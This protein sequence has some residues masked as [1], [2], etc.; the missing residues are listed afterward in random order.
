M[1]RMERKGFSAAVSFFLGLIS[2]TLAA[3]W[4][5][6]RGPNHDGTS[7][8]TDWDPM[9][10]SDSTKP[11]WTASV[12][13]GFSAV[14]VAEGK[15]VTMGNIN[16]NTDVIWCFDAQTGTLLWKHTYDEPLTPNLYEGGPNA[17][18]TIHQGKVYTISKTGK[19]FCLDLN[20]GAVIWQ[21]NA[22]LKKPEWGYAGSPL[23]AGDRIFLN[24]G[25]T[26]VALHKETGA[27]LWQ[28]EKEPCGYATA[29]IFPRQDRFE[30][31]L[32]SKDHLYSVAPEDGRVLWAYPWKTDWDVNASDPVVWAD[33]ILITSGYNR[34]ASVLKV[35][36]EGPKKIWENK[37]LRSQL[38]GPILLD[39]C[40]YGID[41]N[42]LVCLDWKTGQV[43]WTEKS[44]GKGTL[45]AAAGNL[46]VLSENG[47]LMIAPASPKEFS[48]IASAP[49]LKGRCW[50][51]PVLSNGLI[52]AR[53]AKGD[54][55]CIDVR[56][57]PAA[58][59][60]DSPPILAA[61]EMA[62]PSAGSDWACW[63][64]PNRDNRSPET[65]LLKEWPA[66]GPQLL[67][68]ADDLGDGYSS[69]CVAER[70]IFV[71]GL[72][73]KRGVLTCLDWDGNRLW[74]ADYG[75]E[76]TGS[77]PGVRGAP[78]A[79]DGLLYVLSGQGRLVCFSPETGREKWAAELY[80]EFQGPLPRWGVS[81]APVAAEGKVFVT[82]GGP[83]TTMAAVDAQKGHVVWTTE[84]L[85]DTA[86][87][88]TPAIFQWAG[89]TILAGMTEN[90]LFAVEAAT[91]Q[92]FWK[93]PMKD[94][95]KGRNWGVH[96]NTPI[97]YEGRLLF[98]SGYD[99]GS[100]KF[101]FTQDGWSLQREWTNQEFDCHHGGVV[102]HDSYVYGSTWKNNEDGLWACVDWKTGELMYAQRWHNKGSILWAD[103]LFYAYAEKPGVI[104]LIKADSKEFVPVS[105]MTITL[106]DKQHWA[107]PVISHGRL[108]VRRGNTLMVY[109]IRQ[110][111]AKK[112][113][114]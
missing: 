81:M 30:V 46:I 75:P 109:S 68:K 65:G 83:K 74:T 32:F 24:A 49:I 2:I 99:M 15:A 3:D 6:W 5:C 79:A 66:E 39:G 90:Y 14:S 11:L 92:L 93:Y 23:I 88:C 62:E 87:Y 98:V 54:L 108:F 38:S 73:D 89:R 48:V 8:E 103:G 95:I 10:L 22:D 63:R 44:V 31:L 58:S 114:N 4:P 1:M 113:V 94:Y 41:E 105:E 70:K 107:H 59:L 12:G 18:P 16:K 76:W 97:F 112:N 9:V 25:S 82:I 52:Y 56:R 64:G 34:G 47:R 80:T 21:Q 57:K 43:Q 100:V 50:T 71:T 53:N 45:M 55:V 106:G 20:S 84:S 33:E 26:G 69:V 51:M 67:W 17:T 111:A 72:K 61:A 78:V 91:G 42:Q 35:T 110:N 86:S 40:V 104:G 13:T 96:P 85:N 102:F 27:V 7:S 29:V 77:F 36:P 19:V 101:T 60:L 37:N 28:S